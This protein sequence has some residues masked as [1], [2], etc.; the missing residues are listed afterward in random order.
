[1]II[2]CINCTKKFDVDSSLIPEEGRLLQCNNCK[3]KWFF[4][5]NIIKEQVTPAKNKILTEK[6][7]STNETL[8]SAKTETFKSINQNEKN[9]IINKKLESSKTEDTKTIKLFEKN[10]NNNKIKKN[11]V[12]IE[13]KE[14][15]TENLKSKK[16]Y[17]ILG[18]IIVFIISFIALIIILD[19]FQN[20]I[21]KIVPNIEF[22]L[23]NL[24][25]SIN[26]IRLFLKDLI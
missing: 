1:M 22:L 20:P 23:Y 13:K 17:N 14:S 4:R 5:K 15:N 6:I 25:E 3:H 8:D 9:G 2:S 11:K 10:S 12:I 26:D 7:E 21:S 18:I 19:T 16:N 24:Y